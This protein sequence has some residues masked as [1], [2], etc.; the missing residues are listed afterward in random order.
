LL[1][2]CIAFANLNPYHPKEMESV[3]DWI[4]LQYMKFL[5]DKFITDTT[6]DICTFNLDDLL[7]IN[8]YRSLGE[9]SGISALR[10]V[11]MNRPKI[12]FV[13]K[14]YNCAEYSSEKLGFIFKTPLTDL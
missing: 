12:G 4:S 11:A 6:R 3:R 10:K 14:G 2:L 7:P 8:C 13:F 5:E 9:F 1:N